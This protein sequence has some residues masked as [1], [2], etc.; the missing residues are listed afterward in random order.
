LPS[1]AVVFS[2]DRE[3]GLE[4]MLL[5]VGARMGKFHCVP[6]VATTA[7]EKRALWETTGADAVEMESQII[8]AV[9]REQKIPS[10]I[11][12]VI[13]DTAEEDLPLDFNRLM[14]ASQQMDYGKLALA[15]VKSPGKVASLL[16]LQKQSRA[17]AEKL[18]QVLA[19]LLPLN[20]EH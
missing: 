10:A 8:C 3:T 5:A 9:C 18:A 14:N 20:T 11:V 4:P 12:R 13:L 16:R 17:A 7:R 19:K 6:K 1:G 2:A 15:L